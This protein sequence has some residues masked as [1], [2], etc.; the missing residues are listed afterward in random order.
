MKHTKEQMLEVHKENILKRIQRLIPLKGPISN[1]DAFNMLCRH[2]IDHVPKEQIADEYEHL[3]GRDYILRILSESTGKDTSRLP[4]VRNIFA[5]YME[6]LGKKRPFKP[7]KSPKQKKKIEQ[8]KR[9]G[10]GVI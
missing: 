10:L 7:Y 9:E 3:V 8:M 6:I 4:A 5:D 2:Y 1:H